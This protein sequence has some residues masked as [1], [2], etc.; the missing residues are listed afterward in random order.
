MNKAIICIFAA[1]VLVSSAFALGIGAKNIQIAPEGNKSVELFIIND[2]HKD[3]FVSIRIIEGESLGV[4]IVPD[5]FSIDSGEYMAKFHVNLDF[6]KITGSSI[7]IAASESSENSGQFS[8]SANVIYK[9]PIAEKKQEQAETPEKNKSKETEL[10]QENKSAEQIENNL[11]NPEEQNESPS[12]EKISGASTKEEKPLAI[13]FNL[14]EGDAK[15]FA[16]MAISIIALI[17]V[18]DIFFMKK[19]TPLEKYVAKA[20]KIGKTDE[21]IRNKLKEAGWTDMMIEPFLK[22]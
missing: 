16:F 8:A 13:D 20:R 10:A 12:T 14:K 2:E 15:K 7:K 6:D 19:K 9:L 3:I 17:I 5:E 18:I 11:K 21:E 1:L 22:K 4:E